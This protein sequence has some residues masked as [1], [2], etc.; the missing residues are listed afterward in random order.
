MPIP[1]EELETH[2][3]EARP[4]DTVRAIRDWLRG[5]ERWRRWSYLAIPWPD[6]RWCAVAIGDIEQA[7]ETLGRAILDMRLDQVPDLLQPGQPA[8]QARDTLTVARQQQSSNPGQRLVVLRDVR[9]QARNEVECRRLRDVRSQARNEVECRVVVGLLVPSMRGLAPKIDLWRLGPDAEA[10]PWHYEESALV[11]EFVIARR[12]M[13][14]G[15]VLA[16]LAGKPNW[17]IWYIVVPW[18]DG[19]WA[20][21]LA[22]DLEP[23]LADL[24][25]PALS[26]TLEEA[27]QLEP[28]RAVAEGQVPWQE[29]LAIRDDNP[30]RRLVVLR[31][32]EPAGLLIS[33]TRHARP[34]RAGAIIEIVPD[35]DQITGQVTAVRIEAVPEPKAKNGGSEPAG[36]PPPPPP[37]PQPEVRPEVRR[38]TD[39]RFPEEVEVGQQYGLRVAITVTPVE[40]PG[41][42]EV[43]PVTVRPG[44]VD[45]YLMYSRRDFVLEGSNHRQIEVPAQ[46]DSAPVVFDLTPVSEGAKALTV[47]FF[48]D[49]R[50]LTDV[51]VETT[52]VVARPA[53]EPAKPVVRAVTAGFDPNLARW[54]L[55][56]RIQEIDAGDRLYQFQV[57]TPVHELAPGDAGGDDWTIQFRANPEDYVRD[58]LGELSK[59]K[60]MT[61]TQVQRRLS[62]IGTDLW[63]ELVP[64]AV[65]RWY[66]QTIRPWRLAHPD[67]AL[68]LAI[69][70]SEPWIPWEMLRPYGPDDQGRFVEDDFLCETFL[71]ARWLALSTWQGTGRQPPDS[72]D[73]SVVGLI[74]PAS[75]LKSAPL[76]AKELATVLSARAKQIDAD[77]DTLYGVL[78]EGGYRGLH[79][80][81]HGRYNPDKPD[82]SVLVLG[83]EALEP[84]DLSGRRLNFGRDQP[85]V[86]LNACEVGQVGYSLTRLGGWAPA[87]LRAG[88]SVFIGSM[89]RVTDTLAADFAEAFYKELV[90]GAPVSQAVRQARAAIKSDTDPSWLGY[91]LY[92]HPLAKV[93]G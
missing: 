75:G 50:W 9:S 42:A 32:G 65:Q 10:Y 69:V 87:F 76:E 33:E 74:V 52:A 63:D 73:L 67:R 64:P 55:T 25:Q 89:F 13:P 31:G 59:L 58:L 57:A 17:R 88:A 28:G 38:Y 26:M 82:E 70:S 81:G 21:L 68:S 46:S 23:W 40:A 62:I 30:R 49:G 27:G 12:Q 56:L 83:G 78:E 18:D 22:A 37:A 53:G 5:D 45:V 15:E 39:V 48:Q 43:K 24:G 54:D 66:W 92:A 61:S 3:I 51:R 79:F 71:L 29:V 85:L 41:S 36:A 47:D 86:F 80:I 2:F 34:G 4:D 1:L 77:L 72:L 60:K 7:A 11:D 8:D 35:V 19:H 91:S 16:L 20:A 84:D 93:R 44:P 6:G 14:V 90:G